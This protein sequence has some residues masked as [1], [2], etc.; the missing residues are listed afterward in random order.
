MLNMKRRYL[1]TK[2]EFPAKDNAMGVF[3]LLTLYLKRERQ[4]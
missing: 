1:F 3:K 4:K 2:F